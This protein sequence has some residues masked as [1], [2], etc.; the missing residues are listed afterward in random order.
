MKS[1][2]VAKLF[3]ISVSTLRYYEKL[4]VIP[5]I[6]RDKVGYRNFTD[7]DLNWIYLAVKLK[8]SGLSLE[9]MIKFVDLAHSEKDTN[10]EQKDLLREQLK[11]IQKKITTL[12]KTKSI[13]QGKL[14]N[15]DNH[16][17]KIK[18]GELDKVE[19]LWEKYK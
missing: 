17:A 14:D 16:L 18:T 19:K 8:E 7:R 4:G 1:K 15:F 13:L 3:N 9:S 11:E 12:E 10:E 5:E 2:E 6:K